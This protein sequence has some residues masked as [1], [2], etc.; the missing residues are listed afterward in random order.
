MT[1]EELDEA[2]RRRVAEMDFAVAL[3]AEGISAVVM[4][5]DGHLVRFDP[6][7]DSETRLS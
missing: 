2:I 6:S 1:D 5:E 3:K 4:D 7:D